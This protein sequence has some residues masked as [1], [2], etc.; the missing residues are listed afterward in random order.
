MGILP[1]RA[2]LGAHCV[3]ALDMQNVSLFEL[4][5]DCRA[6]GLFNAGTQLVGWK[7]AQAFPRRGPGRAPRCELPLTQGPTI[8][9]SEGHHHGHVLIQASHPSENARGGNPAEASRALVAT[10]RL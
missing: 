9:S 4:D 6:A 10:K 3:P 8:R 7:G 5:Q 2:T 1:H